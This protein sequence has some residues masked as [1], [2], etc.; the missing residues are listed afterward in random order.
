MAMRISK[1]NM[2]EFVSHTWNAIKGKC[3]HD[4]K[5]CYMKKFKLNALRL[6]SKELKTDLGKDNFIFVGS[7]CDVFAKDVPTEWITK[8][9]KH[10]ASHKNKYLLQS[11]NPKR[12]YELRDSIPKGSILGTTIESNRKYKQM[13]NTPDVEE[14]A[15][16]LSELR[17]AGFETMVTIEPILDFDVNELA[18]IINAARPVWVNIGADSK[19]HNLPE[20]SKEKILA[21]VDKL[22]K[23]TEIRKK[24]NLGRILD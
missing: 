12:I 2:Y 23:F 24:I 8:T 6:D 19:E 22:N 5:Y 18:S 10:C 13:G 15:F 3:S 17:E 11:K 4:C 16:F 1:G 14:R 9:L 7:S 21:L 20:P